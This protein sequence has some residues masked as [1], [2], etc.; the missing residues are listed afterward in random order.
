MI[1][2]EDGNFRRWSGH[3]GGTLRNG[4]SAL[5]KDSRELPVPHSA[6]V[7]R[8]TRSRPSPGTESAV[9][10]TLD[11]L[12]SRTKRNKL[13]LISQPVYG[14]LLWQPKWTK[15]DVK[16]W[17]IFKGANQ[18]FQYYLINK[19]FLCPTDFWWPFRCTLRMYL[20]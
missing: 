20:K 2:L 13:L 9:A 7:Q 1:I 18:L 11:F 6:T 15:A 10:L 17:R 5:T 12:A 8:W 16:W 19:S 3:E 14:I 4:I